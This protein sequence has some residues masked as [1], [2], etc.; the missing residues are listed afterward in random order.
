MCVYEGKNRREE[1]LNMGRDECVIAGSKKKKKI[2]WDEG[3]GL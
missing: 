3:W 1:A 2:E